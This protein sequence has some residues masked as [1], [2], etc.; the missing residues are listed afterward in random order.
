MTIDDRRKMNAAEPSAPAAL[1]R[2]P[3]LQG[4][5]A[6][7]AL[8]LWGSLAAC[9]PRSPFAGIDITGANYATGFDLTDHNG[10][11]RT[12]VDF[13]GQVVAVFFGFV[14]CP[15]VCP[16]SMGNLAQARRLLGEQAERMQVLFVSLDPARDTPEVMR[17]YM[18][19]FDP[20]F[21][22]LYT[23]EANLPELARSFRVYFKRVEGRTP[24]S[25]TIDHSAGKFLFDPQGRVRLHHAFGS[26]AEAIA[27]DVRLLLAE[28][29]PR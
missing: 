22:A 18:A 3:L 27:A 7:G 23:A 26:P 29:P 17:A 12:L 6:L 20:T 10:Q 16:T 28:A 15:D 25:Y 11:R 19:A 8:G 24:G 13:R 14:H 4:T 21:L 5:A 1:R 9:S 2:R